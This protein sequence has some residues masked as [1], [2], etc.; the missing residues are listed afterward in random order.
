MKAKKIYSILLILVCISS[1]TMAQKENTRPEFGIEINPGWTLVGIKDSDSSPSDV[2]FTADGHTEK[3]ANQESISLRMY[4]DFDKEG[5]T[6][7]TGLW[8]SQ[9][10]MSLLNIDGS[11]RGASTYDVA[12][13]QLPVIFKKQIDTSNERVSLRLF[14]GP[15]IDFKFSEK[16]RGPDFAHF[17]NLSRNRLD[18]DP[19][20]G[21]N[22]NGKAVKLFNPL[23]V[24]FHLGAGLNY[25][26]SDD[27]QL[28][29]GISGSKAFFNMINPKLRFKDPE[30]TKVREELRITSGSLTIDMGVLFRL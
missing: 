6:F 10:K 13:F 12:Y 14:A 21:R 4:A 8:F 28:Y 15:S 19:T 25:R 16:L 30:L 5:F 24:S 26:L 20:R 11:Y 17:W 3:I 9:K 7:S 23:D 22:G 1:T 27:F 29:G 2:D 18:L